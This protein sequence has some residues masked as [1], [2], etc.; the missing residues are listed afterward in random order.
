MNKEIFKRNV[1]NL[2]AI[3]ETRIKIGNGIY[4]MIVEEAIKNST[5]HSQIVELRRDKTADRKVT[6]RLIKKALKEVGKT[7]EEL[8]REFKLQKKGDLFISGD[9]KLKV[10]GL[11]TMERAAE[12]MLRK[13]L[14]QMEL[15]TKFLAKVKGLGV[16]T[17]AQLLTIVGDMTRFPTPSSLWHYFGVHVK[18]GLAVNPKRGVEST[19]NPKA[20]AL[21]LGVIGENFLRQN[22]PYRTIYDR[23][24]AKTKRTKPIIWNMN[25]DGTKRKGK[26]MHPKHGYKDAIRVMMKRFLCEFW[27]AG[28]LA[29][30]I[31]P[32]R[33][34]Y[35]LNNPNHHLDPDIIAFG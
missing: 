16:L 34:P 30:G 6:A 27:K 15:Y 9:K 26:N 17:S 29:K 4:A 25:P 1:R 21:L 20:K 11:K 7:N 24:S 22:S 10:S 13:D 32:P 23:R 35:I 31:Q 8:E 19:W 28:Y 5:L 18:D 2:K 33:N 12:K 3:Q 14:A